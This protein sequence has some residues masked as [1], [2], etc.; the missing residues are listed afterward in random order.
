M[1][2]GGAGKELDPTHANTSPT[3]VRTTMASAETSERLKLGV[4]GVEDKN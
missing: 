4:E 1:R 2:R 3:R